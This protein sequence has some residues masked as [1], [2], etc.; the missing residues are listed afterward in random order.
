MAEGQPVGGHLACQELLGERG[1][2]IGQMGFIADKTSRPPKPS[3]RRVST[4]W[5]AA[6]PPPTI[7][8]VEVMDAFITYRGR[9]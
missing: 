1:P 2:L 3:R 6:W 9:G 5:A 4:A 8:M 7:K